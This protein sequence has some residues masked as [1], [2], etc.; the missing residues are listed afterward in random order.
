MNPS[1]KSKTPMT[2]EHK[3]ALAEGRAQGRAVRNYL[4]ALEANRPKRG[5]KRTPESINRRL[6]TI[7]QELDEVSPTKR[8]EL[9]QE[10]IDLQAELDAI[11]DK[12]DMTALEAEFKAN[13]KGYSE[14]KG[15]SY[16][17]WRELGVEAS[18]LK[19]AG[20]TRSS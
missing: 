4:E 11:E 1:N 18:L 8:L 10:R 19:D 7:D 9:V 15:I 6:A 12:P 3:A 5:R 13:A 2:D 14:R 20:I 17:A 16:A